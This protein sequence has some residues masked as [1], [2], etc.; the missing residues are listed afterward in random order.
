M[1][2]VV[3]A[4]IFGRRGNKKAGYILLTVGIGLSILS[5]IGNYASYANN[6]FYDV[7]I[8]GVAVFIN[9]I[10]YTVAFILV[11][12]GKE[13][14]EKTIMNAYFD[15]LT[16]SSIISTCSDR[17]YFSYMGIVPNGESVKNKLNDIVDNIGNGMVDNTVEGGLKLIEHYS[18]IHLFLKFNPGEVY[19]AEMF[20][21]KEYGDCIRDDYANRLVY[22][23][24]KHV[25]DEIT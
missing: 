7:K 14:S 16:C 6:P 3:L 12:T 20:L 17:N 15:A 5:T 18:K 24:Q 13:K 1:L 21:K 4:I 8:N 25:N 2:F 23:V 11:A 10:A 22:Y 9:V 19:G